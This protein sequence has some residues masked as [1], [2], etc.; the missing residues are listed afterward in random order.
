MNFKDI[1]NMTDEELARWLEKIWKTGFVVGKIKN[2]IIGDVPNF[3]DRLKED[4]K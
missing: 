1:R 4:E 3:Y 2:S